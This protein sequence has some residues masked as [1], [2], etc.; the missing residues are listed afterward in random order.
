MEL[1]Q[2]FSVPQIRQSWLPI[3]NIYLEY[4]FEV[5]KEAGGHI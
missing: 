1:L 2:T 3:E 4:D 5:K